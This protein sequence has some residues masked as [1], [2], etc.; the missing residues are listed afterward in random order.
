MPS[1]LSADPPVKHIK[2]RGVDFRIRELTIGEYDDLEKKATSER[3]NP[4]N[5]DG[6]SIEVVDRQQLLR[7]MV[8]KCVV[9]P[10]LTAS[11]FADLPA[12]V[13]LGLN[14]YVNKMH[15]PDEKDARGDLVEIE[16]DDEEENEEA[17]GE[18]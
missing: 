7:M 5:P 11:K 16:D 1:N 17:Q 14:D 2:I 18:G 3:P 15:F 9:E 4:V 8:L 12:R 10:H 13:A 6:P